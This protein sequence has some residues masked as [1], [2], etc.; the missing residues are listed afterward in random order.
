MSK[1]KK[2]YIYMHNNKK[3]DKKNKWSKTR[4]VK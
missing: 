3:K 1:E 2:M 4:G